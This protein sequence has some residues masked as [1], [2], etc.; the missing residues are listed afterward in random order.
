M[1]ALALV[2]ATNLI[3]PAMIFCFAFVPTFLSSL[4]F[5]PALPPE[6]SALRFVLFVVGE[7]RARAREGVAVSVSIVYRMNCS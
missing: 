6:P 1:M 3:G 4:D 7:D 2:V 5:F